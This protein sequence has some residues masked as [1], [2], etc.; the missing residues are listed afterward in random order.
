[1]NATQTIEDHLLRL[2]VEDF[3]WHEADLL[4]DFQYEEWLDLLTDDLSYWMPIRRNVPS[5]EM[6]GEMTREG[7][8]LSWYT[9][10]KP[11]LE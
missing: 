1:M 5:R 3:L 9:D 4:D 7:P 11:T 2:E 6:E 10:D 8:D